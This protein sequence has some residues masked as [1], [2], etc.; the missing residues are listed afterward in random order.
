MPVALI[1]PTPTS[2]FSLESSSRCRVIQRRSERPTNC[3]NHRFRNHKHLMPYQLRIGSGRIGS[4]PGIRA[5]NL[6]V[7]KSAQ[8]VWKWSVVFAECRRISPFATVYHR[9]CCT[10][11]EAPSQ[12]ISGNCAVDLRDRVSRRRARSRNASKITSLTRRSNSPTL[13]PSRDL[14]TSRAAVSS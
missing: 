7:N 12:L 10:T 6:A 5:L 2:D 4:G 3:Q 13:A 9:R 1:G 14:K 8:S 11:G